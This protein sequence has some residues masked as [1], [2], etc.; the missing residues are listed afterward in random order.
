MAQSGS[1]HNPPTRD[2]RLA[3]TA[4]DR[5]LRVAPKKRS[6]PVSPAHGSHSL[7]KRVKP[8]E[9]PSG[10]VTTSLVAKSQGALDDQALALARSSGN[11]SSG[12]DGTLD[13]SNS[14]RNHP[15]DR[16]A[17]ANR[18]QQRIELMMQCGQANAQLDTR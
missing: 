10:D 6:P 5:G 11:T 17:L 14:D 7:S 18:R 3:S 4:T 16:A 13:V 12:V 9:H 2:P 1:G 8:A 15:L